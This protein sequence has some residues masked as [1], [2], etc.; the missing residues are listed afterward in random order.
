M[1]IALVPVLALGALVW[2][3]V[4]VL[5]A[6]GAGPPPVYAEFVDQSSSSY[7]DVQLDSSTKGYGAFSAVLPGDG[8]VWPAGRVEASHQNPRALELHYEGAGYR[9]PQ[10][11]PGGLIGDPPQPGRKPQGVHLRLVG[12]VN[13]AG[14]IASVDVWV[15]GNRHHIGSAGQVSGAEAVVDDFLA[16]LRTSD[17]DK[18][19]GI[20]AAYMRNGIRRS[21]FVTEMANAGAVTC[22]D[23]AETTGPTTYSTTRAGASEART[24]IRLTYG[25]C[26]ATARVDAALV[27]VVDGGA[28]KVLSL[29]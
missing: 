20:E 12:Q 4:A 2:L 21:D 16:A 13:A 11:Q 5:R 17:W 28:W 18:L 22:V 25:P 15:N 27:L 19:Y 24:P 10:V 23:S 7:L 3:G 8:R 6:G 1:K 14:H 29:E 26:A 9:D